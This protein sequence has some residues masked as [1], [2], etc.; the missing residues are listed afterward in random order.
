MQLLV[1]HLV[2]NKDIRNTSKFIKEKT[3][4]HH[5]YVMFLWVSPNMKLT[6]SHFQFIS[7]DTEQCRI[8]LEMAK[9]VNPPIIIM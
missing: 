7:I 2:H 1:Q 9:L 3:L 4:Q 6:Q 8:C 5:F